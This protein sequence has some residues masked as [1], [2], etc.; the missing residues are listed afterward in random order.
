MN[1]FCKEE[2]FS[3]TYYKKNQICLIEKCARLKKNPGKKKSCDFYKETI[4]KDRKIEIISNK[5][6][7]TRSNPNI[8]YKEKIFNYIYLCE[9][10]GIN[11]N[12]CGNIVYNMS[13]CGYKYIPHEK[14]SDLKKRLND[15]PD[16][17]KN[18]KSIFPITLVNIPE[19][20]KRKISKN[21]KIK[22]TK[23][24]FDYS[25]ISNE[26]SDSEDS[27]SEKMDEENYTFDI[28][29]IVSEEEIEKNFNVDYCSD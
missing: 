25:I 7:I 4:L 12:Y 28:E 14:L 21:N 3:F 29:D 1:C 11:E 23:N 8:D 27:S 6:E 5:E 19:N 17:I 10:F 18:N 15:F 26:N 20:L 24:I 13:V 2:V 9:N 22:K 16:K